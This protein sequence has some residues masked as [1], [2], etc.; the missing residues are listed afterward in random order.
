MPEAPQTMT[1]GA[2]DTPLA[3]ARDAFHIEGDVRY[4]NCAYLAPLLKRVEAEGIEGIRRRRRPQ[5]F[6]PEDFFTEAD[7]ARQVFATLVNAPSERIALI[8][9]VSYGMATVAANLEVGRGQ[10]S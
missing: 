3:C 9:S 10:T 6:H 2:T 5:D 7:R 1:A 4:L 8:P